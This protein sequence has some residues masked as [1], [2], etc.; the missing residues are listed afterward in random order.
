MSWHPILTLQLRI[1]M[2]ITFFGDAG[3]VWAPVRTKTDQGIRAAGG[4]GVASAWV[5]RLEPLTRAPGERSRTAIASEAA[6]TV[7]S[8]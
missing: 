8:G 7:L 1:S 4:Q 5:E 2:Y 6:G 3:P